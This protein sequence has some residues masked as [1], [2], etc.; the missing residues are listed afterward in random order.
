V[1][2]PWPFVFAS[3]YGFDLVH[4]YNAT[5][6]NPYFPK[7]LTEWAAPVPLSIWGIPLILLAGAAIFLF[8]RHPGVWSPFEVSAMA[9]TLG[10]GL[11]A[12]RSIPWFTLTAALLLPSLLDRELRPRSGGERTGGHRV[13]AIGGVV[14]ATALLAHGLVRP[15]NTLATDWPQQGIASVAQVLRE[16]PQAR[17]FASYDLADWILFRTPEARGRIAFDGRWEILPPSVFRKIM[18]FQIQKAPDWEQPSVGYRLLVLNPTSFS[19]L[20]T[21]YERRPGVRVLYRSSRVVVLDRGPAA[22]RKP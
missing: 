2:A 21:T 19:S 15:G 1:I 9:F 4:Y 20:V 11:L 13:L 7:F 18:Y 6:R 14:F 10:G 16:D 8:A 5:L 22:D 12:V 3:P 17:V